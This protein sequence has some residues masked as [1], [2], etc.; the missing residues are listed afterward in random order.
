MDPVSIVQDAG[1]AWGPVRMGP[2]N[3][4]PSKLSLK[5][6]PTG[7]GA[8]KRWRQKKAAGQGAQSTAALQQLLLK[9]CLLLRLRYRAVL[10]VI[11]NPYLPII[12][13]AKRL[14]DKVEDQL[15][16]KDKFTTR[17]ETYKDA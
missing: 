7:E 6:A 15:I 11:L 14:C 12:I 8:V 3:L 5:R 17:N 1:W 4:A 2:K 13:T 16:R 10:C 9:G